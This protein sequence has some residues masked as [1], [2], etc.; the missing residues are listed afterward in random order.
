V[1]AADG[2]LPLPWLAAP[3]RQGLDRLQAHALLVHG[4]RGVGQFELSLT[5]AQ[6]WLCEA[7]QNSRPCGVCASCRMVQAHTH[8]DLLV[9]LP[10]ALRDVLGWGSPEGEEGGSEKAGKA[11]PSKEIKVDA[12]RAA[13][14]FAQTTSARGRGKVVLVHPA[15]RLNGISANTLLKTLEEPPGDARFVLSCA[16]PD[17]LL[18]T[19]RSRCQALP[20]GLPPADQAAAW[21]AGQGV[22]RSEVL[23]AAAGGQPLD[24]LDWQRDGIDA[25]AWERLPACVERGD[26]AALAAWPLSRLVDALQ[27]L[28]HDAMCVAVGAPPRYFEPARMAPG[29]TLPALLAWSRELQRL[30]RHVE[31]PW[32]AGLAVESLVRQGRQALR[33]SAPHAANQRVA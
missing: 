32:S 3:L 23:L 15:E 10:E 6:A 22:A 9:L 28:C 27:K 19:V 24:A 20:L 7:A 12:V 11:K 18:P 8:P 31:H 30:S 33:R 21:L 26:A 5:L 13:V 4:P 29:A 1:V 17:A 14:A 16:E 2:A 25:A